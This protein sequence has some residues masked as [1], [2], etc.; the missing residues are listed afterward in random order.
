MKI[1]GGMAHT[2]NFS[3]GETEAEESWD[4]LASQ[5]NLF[6]KFQNGERPCPLPPKEDGQLA[7]KD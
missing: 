6:G 7:P 2:W 4:S 5:P 1:S 3:A